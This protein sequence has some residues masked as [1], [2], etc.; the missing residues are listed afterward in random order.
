LDVGTYG[1]AL[2]KELSGLEPQLS[3][4]VTHGNATR[5]YAG[6][7]DELIKR[8][9]EGGNWKGQLETLQ[10]LNF[11]VEEGIQKKPAYLNSQGK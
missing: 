11:V 7:P 1:K 2:E 6:G 10:S 9:R 3:K 5:D 4:G 8:A